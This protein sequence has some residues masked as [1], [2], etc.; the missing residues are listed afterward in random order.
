M[1]RMDN[2]VLIVD[3]RKLLPALEGGKLKTF[4]FSLSLR[5]KKSV[6]LLK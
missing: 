5:K 1:S 2:G 4:L 3:F 6:L